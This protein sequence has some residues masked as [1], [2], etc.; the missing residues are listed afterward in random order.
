[1]WQEQEQEYLETARIARLATAD[2]TG[3]PHVV[4]VCFAIVDD[5]IVTPIDEKPQQAAPRELRRCRDVRDNPHVALLVDH[6]TEEW[7]LLGWIRILG[8]AMLCS[9]EQRIHA[10][11]IVGLRG[12]YDQYVDHDLESRPL[13][14]IDPG[15]VQSWGS[16]ERPK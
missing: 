1:M 11:G 12:K 8:R 10:K 7:P 13:I 4:P 9:P 5:R 2:A 3:R 15:S 16:L 14:L 6:Y